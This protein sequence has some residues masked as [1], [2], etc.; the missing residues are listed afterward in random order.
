VKPIDRLRLIQRG[1]ANNRSLDDAGG[2]DPDLSL[3]ERDID[4]LSDSEFEKVWDE[5]AK[6]AMRAEAR[7]RFRRRRR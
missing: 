2:A 4:D 6:K 5:H 1:M 3:H 7:S